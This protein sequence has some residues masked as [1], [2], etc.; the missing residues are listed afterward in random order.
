MAGAEKLASYNLTSLAKP[1][2]SLP[3]LARCIAS[4][5]VGS[6][7]LV[8][9]ISTKIINCSCACRIKMIEQQQ[10]LLFAVGLF[11]A[12]CVT[13]CVTTPP[14]AKLLWKHGMVCLKHGWLHWN[15]FWVYLWRQAHKYLP[16]IGV[17]LEAQESLEGTW[18]YSE[19][20]KVR[21]Q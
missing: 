3:A 18:I 20:G 13:T 11:L 9:H 7:V 19:K 10:T 1:A 16:Q 14:V 6:L 4:Q 2:P 5:E 21:V 12:F 15:R 17:W 8:Q